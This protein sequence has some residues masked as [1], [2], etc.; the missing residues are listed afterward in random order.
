[1]ILLMKLALKYLNNMVLEF[2]T[3][4]HLD[5]DRTFL[6][7]V[8]QS[9]KIL[10]YIHEEWFG[11]S[12]YV[13]TTKLCEAGTEDVLRYVRDMIFAMVRRK[14]R[15]HNDSCLIER[16]NCSTLKEKLAK[17]IHDMFSLGEGRYIKPTQVSLQAGKPKPS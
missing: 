7:T 12:K 14:L 9:S 10:Y 6:C 15:W 17:D 13:F 5:N 1:M 2:L 16:R 11:D 4:C 3:D 8:Q